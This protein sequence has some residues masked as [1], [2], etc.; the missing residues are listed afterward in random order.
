MK[1][2]K[3]RYDTKLYNTKREA[4]E[5]VGEKHHWQTPSAYYQAKRSITKEFI[6]SDKKATRYF[7]IVDN[8]YRLLEITQ[9]KEY[10]KYIHRA[11]YNKIVLTKTEAIKEFGKKWIEE[12]L[13]E[14]EWMG[15]NL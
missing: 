6:S 5:A 8:L 1:N 11:D 7:F 14:R 12:Q 10:A 4:L 9:D 3:W 2:Y 13:E 15:K